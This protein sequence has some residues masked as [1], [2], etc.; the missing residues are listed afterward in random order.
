MN[1]GRSSIAIWN[2]ITNALNNITIEVDS[3]ELHFKNS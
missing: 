1:Y 3:R 2:N